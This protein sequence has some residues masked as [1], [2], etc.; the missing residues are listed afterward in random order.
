MGYLMESYEDFLN[1][2]LYPRD[3][4]SVNGKIVKT[5]EGRKYKILTTK[6]DPKKSDFYYDTIMK[7]IE[8]LDPE[9][10]DVDVRTYKKAIPLK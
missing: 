2:N 4:I 9:D 3:I 6:P 8:Q 1:E 10:W 7:R 5:R